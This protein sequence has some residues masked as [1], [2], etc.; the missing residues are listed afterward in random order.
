MSELRDGE[1]QTGEGVEDGGWGGTDGWRS[2]R[3]RM[4]RDRRVE[5]RQM[6]EDGWKDR[7]WVIVGGAGAGRVGDR[8]KENST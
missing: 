8:W 4:E 3:W 5:E 7:C 1:G 2:G 6:E